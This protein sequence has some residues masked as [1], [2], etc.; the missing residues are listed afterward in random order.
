M[1]YGTECISEN[2]MFTYKADCIFKTDGK[3]A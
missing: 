3:L 1:L 2:R